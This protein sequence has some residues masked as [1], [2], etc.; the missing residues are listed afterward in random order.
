MPRADVAGHPDGRLAATWCTFIG[1]PHRLDHVFQRIATLVPGLH[2]LAAFS[3]RLG[4]YVL[5]LVEVVARSYQSPLEAR[6]L[7]RAVGLS[8][9]RLAH[10]VRAKLGAP[11]M[12]YVGR[13]R[14]EV[15]RHLVTVTDATLDDVATQAGFSSASHLSRIFV[16]RS[17]FRPGNYRIQ[18]RN[19]GSWPPP[20][21]PAWAA[22]SAEQVGRRAGPRARRRAQGEPTVA[23]GVRRGRIREKL[24]AGTLPHPGQYRFIP[25][26]RPSV[27]EAT[28]CAAC[29]E[30]IEQGDL[31]CDYLYT[32]GRGVT[33]HLECSALWEQQ[34]QDPAP[35]P[36]RRR[37]RAR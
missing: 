23:T 22:G 21:L 25:R 14:F 8:V 1:T 3:S 18:L 5:K 28:T 29:D 35:S 12:D 30:A 4:P 9:D 15:A 36:S 27:S 2:D 11:L 16:Q 19:R 24:R 10:V 31:M 34:G 13:F 7:A 17:G 37:T 20:S 6:G 26:V 32:S 33:L